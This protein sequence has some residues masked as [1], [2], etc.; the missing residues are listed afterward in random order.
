MNVLSVSRM[1]SLDII[2]EKSK[3]NYS[4]KEKNNLL[5]EKISFIN[6]IY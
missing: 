6:N 5:I 2:L 3:E 1:E 4:L